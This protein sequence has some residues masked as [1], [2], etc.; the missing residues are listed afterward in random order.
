MT[1]KKKVEMVKMIL[2]DKTERL[3]YPEDVKHREGLGW[4]KVKK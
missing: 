1:D 4:K 3:V 2:L